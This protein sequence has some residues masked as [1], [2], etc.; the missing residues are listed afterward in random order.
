MKMA[1]HKTVTNDETL[2]PYQVWFLMVVGCVFGPMTTYARLALLEKTSASS[3]AV[4]TSVALFPM[5]IWYTTSQYANRAI[6]T[7]FL[8]SN[9]P[10]TVAHRLT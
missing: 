4:F 8:Y 9:G 10:G 5:R 7:Q 2:A 3:F 6:V 1:E